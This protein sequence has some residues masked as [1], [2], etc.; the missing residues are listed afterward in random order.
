[1]S[2]WLDTH[3]LNV[4]IRNGCKKERS[5]GKQGRSAENIDNDCTERN[6]SKTGHNYAKNEEDGM[7]GPEKKRWRRI[8][9]KVWQF[10]MNS[11]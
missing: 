9:E 11:L 10:L 6:D 5:E 1:M 8:G 4:L 2:D 7:L 3:F